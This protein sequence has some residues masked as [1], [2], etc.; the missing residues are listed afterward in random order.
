MNPTESKPARPSRRLWRILF[1]LGV[2]GAACAATTLI[3]ALD[4]LGLSRD[5]AVLR[6][7]LTAVTGKPATTCVQL[8]V[9]PAI[10]GT[11][12]FG[13]HWVHSIPDEA[14]EAL[15]IVRSASVGVYQ[16]KQDVRAAAGRAVDS[17]DVVMH[18][19]GWT[20]A[21]GVVNAQSTVVV[22]LPENASTDGPESVCFA[23][24]DG[25]DLVV[26]SATLNPERL[27]KFVQKMQGKP[28][29]QLGQLTKL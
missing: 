3:V 4:S 2:G 29:F 5:A 9:G 1:W 8:D 15:A 26:G 11:V 16:M 22:Y 23:V 12:R 28:E 19:R 10:L 24:C 14:R 27:V 20:R 17:I 25:N 7:E 13:I 18:R 21:V 6:R